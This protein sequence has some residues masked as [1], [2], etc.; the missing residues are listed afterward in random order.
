MKKVI[1]VILAI[2]MLALA[3]SA[4]AATTLNG[5]EARSVAIPATSYNEVDDGISPTTGLN[6][7]EELAG[8]DPEETDGF[9]GMAIT[10]KYTPMLVQI[11][12]SE[13][14]VGNRAPWD[15]NFADVVYETPL[16]KRGVTRMSYLF[17]DLIPEYVGPARSARVNHVWIREEWDCAFC[18]WG[19]QRYVATNI[20][21]AFRELGA[22]KKGILFD[23]TT[24]A[25][26]WNPYCGRS[27]VLKK[28]NNAYFMLAGLSV[29]VMEENFTPS[30][31]HT[32]KFT[33]EL[34]EDGDD[35]EVINVAWGDPEYSSMLEYDEDENCYVRYMVM[36]PTDPKEYAAIN[37][38]PF[39]GDKIEKEADR[40]P[41]TFNNVIVQFMN[42][43]YPR[44]DA[45]K[46]E[47]VGTGN[48]EYF[49]GGKHISGVWN[50]SGYAD[51]TVFY[52]MDGNEIEMQRGHTLIIMMDYATEG[53]S[54]SY[55]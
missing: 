20:E 28:P 52:D 18:F 50:R 45:P 42:I 9:S 53:R 44:I 13:G 29:L 15:G 1:S 47:V 40:T 5:G 22:D 49:M 11:D 2:M 17:S 16:Y 34:P 54:V 33:D 27:E 10:G 23:G 39:K 46:P 12:N 32:F 38:V 35:A 19:G 25:K 8:Y 21:E 30:V 31:N 14:G 43:E 36:D 51:R 7:K 41:I 37:P 3:S 55:E 6:L 4:M 26:A 48:A 24:G